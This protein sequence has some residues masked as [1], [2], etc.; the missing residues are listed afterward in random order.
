MNDQVRSNLNTL[1]AYGE[2][3]IKG[4][5]YAN[6][7]DDL[8]KNNPTAYNI[9]TNTFG[10]LYDDKDILDLKK[11]KE[12]KELTIAFKEAFALEF[13]D[14]SLKEKLKKDVVNSFSLISPYTLEHSCQIIFLEHDFEPMSWLCG[15]AE[16]NSKKKYPIL[17]SPKYFDYDIELFAG[18]GKV[19]Y[20]LTWNKMI[21][22]DG[23]VEKL[24]LDNKVDGSS[25][26]ED[27]HRMHQLKMYILLHE[28]FTD[29]SKTL[30]KNIKVT[31][32]LFIYG[33]E[34]DCEPMNIFILE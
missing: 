6:Y 19:D 30:F 7:V 22:L 3:S 12:N 10:K 2:K 1:Y 34:H 4:L 9:D 21:R 13:D 29:L 23:I 14:Y 26:Y 20:S 18:I 24:D 27:L 32:P 17:E 15:Y 25:A 16:N 11:A 28:V 8:I 5:T 33:M 31:K